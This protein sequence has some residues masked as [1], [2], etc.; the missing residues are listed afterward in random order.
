MV[1]CLWQ[2][3]T[4]NVYQTASMCGIAG[5]FVAPVSAPDEQVL[6]RVT[7]A[8][9]HRG[10]DDAG[11]FIAPAHGVA[12]GHRRLSIIDLSTASHQPMLALDGQVA[13]AYNGELYN[14]RELRHEL[15]AA[16]ERFATSGDTEVVL[17]AYLHWGVEAFARFAG[18][19]ALA[20]WDARSGTLHLARDA[21]GIKPLYWLPFRGGIAFA[22]EARALGALPG[23]SLIPRDAGVAQFLEFGYVIDEE[24]TIFSD[25]R[26]LAPG[27]RLELRSGRVVAAVDFF[28]PLRLAAVE[29]ATSLGLDA[30]IEHLHATL[31]EVVAQHLIADVPVATLLSGGID[32]GVVAALAARHTRVQTLTMAFEGAA[33]DERGPAREV[34]AFIGAQH[35]EVFITA[36]EVVA[37]AQ[38][39]AAMFDDLFADWG[40]ITSRLLYRRARELGYKVVLVGE[41]ADELF[42]GY[43]IFAVPTRL[44]PRDRFRLFQHYCGRRYGT[45]WPLFRKVMGEYLDGCADAFDAVRLFE[46]RRQLPNQYV[47]KV[48]KASMAES[49]EARAPYLDHRVAALGY[50]TPRSML[51]AGGENKHLLREMARRHT[52]LP[53]ANT[54]RAKYGSPLNASWMD[55]SPVLRA[56]ARERLLAPGSMTERYGL[57]AAMTDYLVRGRSGQHWPRSISIYRN[58]AWKLLLLELW[59][60]QVLS[61][62]PQHTAAPIT[63]TGVST[64]TPV[65]V[66]DTRVPGLVSTIIPV[67]NRASMLER[68]VRS[69]LA[70]TYRSIE[71]IIVD[72]GSTDDTPQRAAALAQQHPEVVRVVHQANA[73][74]GVARQHGVDVARGEFVQ[75]LD[76]DDRYLPEK[77]TVQVAAL[78]ADPGADIAY[79]KTWAVAPDGTRTP[80]AFHR[81]GER[82][83]H[84]FPAILSGRIWPTN[85]PMYRARSL[86]RMGRWSSARQL[87]DW[88][89]DALAA[90]TRLALA[91]VDAFVAEVWYHEGEHLGRDWV[92]DPRAHRERVEGLLKIAALATLAGVSPNGPDMRQYCRTLFF[93]ARLASEAGLR[94][95]AQRLLALAHGHARERRWELRLYGAAARVVGWRTAGRLAAAWG[96]GR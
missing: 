25:V 20:L 67:F 5:W 52:L 11:M 54:R 45:C 22:S 88:H 94:E 42:G 10:P 4:L 31:S 47:M 27:R 43:S 32:S 96:R 58:L 72:D 93:E 26:K 29:Q 36:D 84:L 33:L 8:L 23:V 30:R 3:E 41:G 21:M 12:L 80:D 69:V 19:F 50:A 68:A 65:A 15:E 38:Q 9:R 73:G 91:Y 44:G 16:G 78:Q 90:A 39:H 81:T 89:Y 59:A 64:P 86:F 34:A 49:I 66:D 6:Q 83:R 18:M 53:D 1:R 71:I 77:T 35:Q 57:K 70:Q 85:N 28:Q 40:T 63:L 74:P 48:D 2:N 24:Q 55:E 79:G 56:V 13:L 82:H 37:E 60:E 14:F 62:A 87:E 95:E 17:R 46:S 7:R 61:P 75:Y 92:R 51:L 76:S